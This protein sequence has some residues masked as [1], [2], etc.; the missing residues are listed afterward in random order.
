MGIY[1]HIVTQI[2]RLEQQGVF[3]KILE[4]ERVVEEHRGKENSA[5]GFSLLSIA[6]AA[7]MVTVG[8]LY[9]D[10]EL[11]RFGASSYLYYGG[12]FSLVVNLLGLASSLAKWWALKDG[13]ISVSERRL[14]WFLGVS[15]SLMLLADL[16]VVIW[17]SV[18]VFSNYAWWSY[19]DTTSPTYCAHT[20]MLFAFVLLLVKWLLIPAL[21]LT[22]C[23]SALCCPNENED[24]EIEN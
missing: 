2:N 16:I 1:K 6:L 3:R 18:V 11:C 22:G 20:P 14:L 13:K 7:A 21:C 10:E 8:S 5:R 17:G 4:S 9:W 12:V 23:I 19:T 24:Q 15:T